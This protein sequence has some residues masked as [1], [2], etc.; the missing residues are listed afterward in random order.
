MKDD[1]VSQLFKDDLFFKQR[2]TDADTVLMQRP[3]ASYNMEA[4]VEADDEGGDKEAEKT[5][6][7]NKASQNNSGGDDEL[8]KEVSTFLKSQTGFSKGRILFDPNQWAKAQLIRLARDTPESIPQIK[9][10]IQ[11]RI[12]SANLPDVLL[13]HR[14][15]RQFPLELVDPQMRFELAE[16]LIAKENVAEAENM[17]ASLL[18]FLPTSK[19]QIESAEISIEGLS[20]DSFVELW[21]KIHDAQYLTQTQ[22]A[23]ETSDTERA[24]KFDYDRVNVKTN[25]VA[26]EYLRN[27]PTVAVPRGEMASRLFKGKSLSIWGAEQEFEV[28]SS[29]G[30]SET[31][32]KMFKTEAERQARSES[33]WIHS[34][35]SL[36]ILRQ[37]DL[38][39]ALDLSKLQL[40]HEAVLWDRK[41]I[42]GRGS[43]EIGD[44]LDIIVN[45]AMR[46]EDVTA[47]FPTTGCCCFID[48][49]NLTC[50]DAFTGET[51]WARTK[52]ANHTNVLANNSQVVT[53]DSK[54]NQCSV[55]DLR[56]GERLQLRTIS[57]VRQSLWTSDGMNFL[58]VGKIEQQSL[59]ELAEFEDY[60]Q[61]VADTGDKE[62]TA[63]SKSSESSRFLSRYDTGEGKFVWKKVFAKDSRVSRLSGERFVV[64]SPDN[65]LYFFDS[66][67]GKELAKHPSGLTEDQL[68]KI[69]YIGGFTHLGKEMIVMATSKGPVSTSSFRA[70]ASYSLSTF[71]SGHIMSLSQ[72]TLEP[73]WDRLAE[74]DGFQLLPMLPSAS[75]ILIMNRRIQ[76]SSRP[77]DIVPQLGVPIIPSSSLQLL[78]LDMNDGHVV[79]NKILGQVG[80]VRFT[81]PV[82]DLAAGTIDMKFADWEVQFVFEKSSDEPPS[83]VVSVTR[84]NP[85]PRTLETIETAAKVAENS[86]DIEKSN[87]RLVKQAEKYE[88]NVRRDAEAGANSDRARDKPI[89]MGLGLGK[90]LPP[91][92]TLPPGLEITSAL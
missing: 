43:K 69:K 4:S 79:V 12:A 61:A 22:S 9:A 35:H 28:L 73:A 66:K 41:V 74:I 13:R 46:P 29:T 88:A 75:P 67:T 11:Q 8:R 1:V 70:R 86:F 10:A 78:S 45:P 71:I 58:A 64:L 51:L 49:D 3:V 85:V 90:R 39:L 68:K 33:G 56:T 72:D 31:R 63:S 82:I 5:D 17:L 60:R 14:F 87:Q 50:V 21:S 6:A 57:D 32:F 38:L 77:R 40:G 18:G 7:S 16:E 62:K 36:A 20:K 2:E 37:R 92:I 53:T 15:L 30:E 59:D 76:S 91:R 84:M 19:I 80:T 83:P 47:S 26:S 65:Q 81:S 23:A 25:R 48:K 42:P 55:F 52:D 89:G 24:A 34:N 54:M 27:Y 44:E